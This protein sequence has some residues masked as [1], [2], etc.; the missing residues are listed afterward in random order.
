VPGGHHRRVPAGLALVLALL[1]LA[2]TLAAAVV[3]SR[4]PVG[5]RWPS[6]ARASRSSPSAR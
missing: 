6:G 5:R 2:G 1:A 4:W 3:H